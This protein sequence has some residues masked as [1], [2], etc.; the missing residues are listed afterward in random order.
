MTRGPQGLENIPLSLP[1]AGRFF[2]TVSEH[3]LRGRILRKALGD[4][5]SQLV[6]SLVKTR[7]ELV[8]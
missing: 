3:L 5:L 7:R 4:V 1:A 6:Y 2:R 8:N